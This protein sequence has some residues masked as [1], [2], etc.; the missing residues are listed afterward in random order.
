VSTKRLSGHFG[1]GGIEIPRQQFVDA[2]DGM[3]GDT[4]QHLVQ[5]GF[6]IETI[7]LRRTD[8]TVDRRGALAASIGRQLI[9][10]GF[11]LTK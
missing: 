10:P 11:W 6:G 5:I 3:V 7:E 8:Q 9:V 2:V 4:R 1:R